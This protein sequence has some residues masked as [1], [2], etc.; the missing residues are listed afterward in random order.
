MT[1]RSLLGPDSSS[2]EEPSGL[3]A[4][5]KG[6]VNPIIH[7][8]DFHLS[9]QIFHDKFSPQYKCFHE[10][11]ILYP[12]RGRV[13][14]QPARRA[15]D[16]RLLLSVMP[17]DR[18]SRVAEH[19]SSRMAVTW[20]PFMVAETKRGGAGRSGS[21]ADRERIGGGSGSDPD[22]RLGQQVGRWR[23]QDSSD[24]EPSGWLGRTDCTAVPVHQVCPSRLARPTA[25]CSPRR[26]EPRPIPSLRPLPTR[27]IPR[28]CA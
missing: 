25:P 9:V 11:Y 6:A 26:T 24:A 5:G 20:T 18:G 22:Q 17:A 23:L 2:R 27:P 15:L 7:P 13:G 3:G 19:T 21:G 8:G 4:E 12:S 1:I 28:A 16:L 14:L 10:I